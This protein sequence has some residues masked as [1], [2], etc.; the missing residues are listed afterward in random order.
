[1]NP[2]SVFVRFV[3]FF[4]T[5]VFDWFNDI[6]TR[7]F[8]PEEEEEEKFNSIFA[9]NGS[10]LNPRRRVGLVLLPTTGNRTERVTSVT[11][12]R[13]IL[14]YTNMAPEFPRNGV[15]EIEIPIQ[16]NTHIDGYTLTN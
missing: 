9:S 10:T 7:T 12:L 8:F 11:R 14:V 3:I 15:T 1:M 16:I 5:F 6:I 13:A 2:F 4:Q